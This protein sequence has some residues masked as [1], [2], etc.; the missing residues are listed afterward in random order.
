MRKALVSSLASLAV[1]GGAVFALSAPAQAT[2]TT[3][4]ST[5]AGILTIECTR[6][7][8]NTWG[9]ISCDSPDG[10]N[11]KEVR[12]DCAGAPDKVYSNFYFKGTWEKSHECAWGSMTRIQ[13]TI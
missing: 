9:K 7:I 4:A 10:Q 2:G 3:T 6:N 8:Q 1:T 12:F 5:S 11:V 13:V